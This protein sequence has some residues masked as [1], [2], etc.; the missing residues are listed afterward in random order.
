MKE[1]SGLDVW[2]SN[3]PCWCQG[4]VLATEDWLPAE[5]GLIEKDGKYEVS[6]AAAGFKPGEIKVSALPDFLIISAESTDKHENEKD[7]HFFEFGRKSMFRQFPLPQ[8]INADNV[9]AI[10]TD[11]IL[12]VTA[13]KAATADRALKA[14]A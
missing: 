11:G 5:R 9:T 6:I 1:L 13:Q 14:G 12:H 4:E 10:L 3:Q 7:I 8:Q 2:I